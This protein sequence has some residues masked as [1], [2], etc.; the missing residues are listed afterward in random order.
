MDSIAEYG[1]AGGADGF[2]DK[3]TTRTRETTYG[4]DFWKQQYKTAEIEVFWLRGLASF[5]PPLNTIL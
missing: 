3:L 4:S 2:Q 5:P 1:E